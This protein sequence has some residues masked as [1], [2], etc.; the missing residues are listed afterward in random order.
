MHSFAMELRDPRDIADVAA[1]IESLCIPPGNGRYTMPDAEERASPR[2]ARCSPWIAPIATS[3]IGQGNKEKATR[4][5]PGQHYRYLVRQME[6]IRDGYRQ[7]VIP[8]WSRPS[9]STRTTSCK[10]SPPTSPAWRPRARPVN[11]A[12]P[13][14]EAR[15]A[16][17]P[18]LDSCQGG[19]GA[20]GR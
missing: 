5:W 9:R 16:L 15:R 13:G 18:A 10:A 3:G 19:A 20:G 6:D 12:R 1:Y 7:A 14:N 4:C 8:T 11:L 2:G 17:G